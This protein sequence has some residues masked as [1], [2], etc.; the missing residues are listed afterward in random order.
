MMEEREEEGVYKAPDNISPGWKQEFSR[1]TVQE[2]DE[3][4][5]TRIFPTIFEPSLFS[6]L[7]VDILAQTG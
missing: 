6:P 3:T 7:S 2:A 5:L 1:A 4:T